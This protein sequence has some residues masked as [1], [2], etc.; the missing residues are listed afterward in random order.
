M[1]KL[2]ALLIL[3]VM[4]VSSASAVDIEEF[5]VYANV[6]GASDLGEPNQTKE[7]SGG[8]LIQYVSDGTRVIFREDGGKLKAVYVI[9]E[10]DAFLQYSA[11]TM[12]FIDTDTKNAMENFGGL[13]YYYLRA[14]TSSDPQVG[15]LASGAVYGVEKKEDGYQ[16]IVRID[17]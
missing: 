15:Y 10:G 7:T 2:F 9:G 14:H 8:T 4:L 3:A 11:A 1:K 13:L 17:N 5:N 12:A 6:M 16:F